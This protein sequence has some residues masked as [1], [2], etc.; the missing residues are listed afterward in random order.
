MGL[1]P[2][3]T[4]RVVLGGLLAVA[5]SQARAAERSGPPSFH[6]ARHQFTLLR[7]TRTLPPTR[8][9]SLDGRAA[10]FA[11]LRGRVTLVNF[12]ATWC[13]ACRT[14]LPMLERLHVTMADQGV[15]VAAISV[16]QGG[17]NTVAPFLRAL[18]IRRLPVYLDPEG[19]VAHADREN[20]RN[21][22]FALYGMPISYVIDRAGR[23]VGYL[24]G[25]ADWTSPESRNLL[26][27]FADSSQ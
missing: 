1:H 16:D 21:A 13:A 27:Y 15:R 6:T 19:L 20:R 25:E 26:A 12:W 17:R 24:P 9:V 18:N 8:L 3:V 7:P 10:D 5:V 22:P 4:R 11:A 23:I 2:N 14:E